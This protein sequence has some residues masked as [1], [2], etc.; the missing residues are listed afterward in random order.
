MTPLHGA[1]GTHTMAE[2]APLVARMAHSHGANGTVKA[3]TP[4]QTHPKITP[5]TKG[6][7]AVA[8]PPSW[9]FRKILI[10]S[11]VHSKVMKELLE[12]NASV[13]T[14]VSWLLYAFSPAGEGIQ[15][16]LS[17]ALASLRD[18]PVEVQWVH[19]TAWQPC[20]PGVLSTHPFV[21]KSRFP[22]VRTP[23]HFLRE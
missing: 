1:N 15:S 22:K 14:F 9:V 5:T 3:L 2:M 20:L 17:Y 10:Q 21:Y 6:G 8:V 23:T 11:R 16:P 7:P 13:H 19:T 4:H 18:N 12:K